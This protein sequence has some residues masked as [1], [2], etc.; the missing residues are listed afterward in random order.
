MPDQFDHVGPASSQSGGMI[1]ENKAI[2]RAAFEALMAGD[3]APLEQLLAPDCVLHQCGWL[4]PIRGARSIE[5]LRANRGPVTERRVQ[6]E[7][8]VA[9]GN[10]VAIHWHTDGV[11][12][13]PD[14]PRRSGQPVS[15]PNMSFLRLEGGKIVEIWNIQDVSTMWSQIDSGKRSSG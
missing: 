5:R 3:P 4:Q 8:M 13:D 12:D 6:L 15:F 7:A 14:D 10:M 11:Y 9:E 1:D 2:A